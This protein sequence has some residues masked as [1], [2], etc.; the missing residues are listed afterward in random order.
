MSQLILASVGERRELDASHFRADGGSEIRDLDAAGK[1]IGIGGVG[2]L[3]VLI[4]LKGLQ[5]GVLLCWVPCGKVVRV[6]H[7][8][9]KYNVYITTEGAASLTVAAGPSVLPASASLSM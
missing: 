6:L 4:V 9:Y 8:A 5:R 7:L 2:I 1:E 3:A